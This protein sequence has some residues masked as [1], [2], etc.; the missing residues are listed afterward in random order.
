M[1]IIFNFSHALTGDQITQIQSQ[2]KDQINEIIIPIH[3]NQDK[4]FLQ[5]VGKQIDYKMIVKYAR[6]QN[7]LLIIPPALGV[8]TC[9]LLAK[10]HGLLG[11]FPSIVRLRPVDQGLFQD[12]Q[13]AE[14]INLQTLR[15]QS[16]KK[17]IKNEVLS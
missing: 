10:L 12:Y 1:K 17:R 6:R 14:I 4:S 16:R 3:F 13:V 2:V 5:Q 9:L 11:Y 8:I 7:G 15:D